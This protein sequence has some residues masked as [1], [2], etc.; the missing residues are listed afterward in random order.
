WLFPVSSFSDKLF[1]VF[2]FG[3]KL[4]PDYQAAN[5]EFALNFNPTNPYCKGIEGIIEAYRMVMPQLR[6]S[7][8]TNFS[9]IINHVSSIAA[10]AAQSN[11]AS[12][13][14]VLLILTDGEIT[15]LDQ[16]R[17]AI[18]RAS[19]LPLSIIIVGVG[20]ADFKAMEL[21]DGD[22]G[23]LKSTVGEAVSRD[24]VQFVPYRQFKDAPQA[25]LAK[26][27]LAEVP[28]QLVSYFKMRGLEPLKPA[29]AAPKS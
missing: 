7:G 1:P 24:I 11:N 14:F 26:S 8:P 13:Y 23:V 10:Q 25:S 22:D 27:V 18:V 20:P 19:R 29:T 9:P 6:L 21:L 28:N 3:A 12:Q 2:G 4:P 5:H 16:T 15:D 17:D